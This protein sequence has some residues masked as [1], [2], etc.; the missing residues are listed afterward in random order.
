[1]L[2]ISK[3][4]VEA[5]A[6]K[7]MIQG[8]FTDELKTVQSENLDFIESI[9]ELCGEVF[10]DVEDKRRGLFVG[11]ISYKMFKAAYEGKELGDM[12]ND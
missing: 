9:I 11:L 8:D 10:E 4:C 6:H 12:W 2:K 7:V 5:V 1:M 3:E